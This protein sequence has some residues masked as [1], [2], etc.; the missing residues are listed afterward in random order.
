MKGIGERERRRRRNQERQT[1][2][3][4]DV[5]DSDN[6]VE[7]VFV[8]FRSITKLGENENHIPIIQI[9][10]VLGAPEKK[11]LPQGCG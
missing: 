9:G 2:A 3:K 8:I 1:D 11:L 6:R 5:L 4:K 7:M 10:T